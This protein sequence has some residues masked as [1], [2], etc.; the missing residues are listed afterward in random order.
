[1]TGF[2]GYLLQTS[3]SANASLRRF[4]AKRPGRLGRWAAGLGGSPDTVV[5]NVS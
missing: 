5:E 1:M 3:V 2:H 4:I